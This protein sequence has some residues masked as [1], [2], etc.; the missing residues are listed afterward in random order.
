MVHG[1]NGLCMVGAW[2]QAPDFGKPFGLVFW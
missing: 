1:K 2:P